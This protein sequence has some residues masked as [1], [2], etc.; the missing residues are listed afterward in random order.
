MNDKLIPRMMLIGVLALALPAA[1][2]AFFSVGISVGFAPPALPL[3]EQPPCPSSGYMWTPGYWAYSAE[4]ADY[5]WVPGTWV[6]APEPGLL[7]TP[8]YWA[9]EEGAYL[10]N[11]GYWAPHVGFYGGINYGYGYFGSGFE[12]GYW[13][14]HDFY[15]N[16]AVTNISNVSITNVYNRTVL[17]SNYYGNRPSFNGAAGVRASPTGSDLAAAHEPHRGI[18][19]P[20]RLQSTSAQSVRG[21]RASINHGN[22]PVAATAR[23]GA[24]QSR[25][26]EPAHYASL[27]SAGRYPQQLSAGARSVAPRTNEPIAR[28]RQEGATVTAW[29]SPAQ[30][31]SARQ[32]PLS[33]QAPA[34]SYQSAPAYPQVPRTAYSGSRYGD[35]YKPTARESFSQASQTRM[36]THYSPPVQAPAARQAP[37]ARQAPAASYRPIQTYAQAPRAAYSVNRNGG[38]YTP[39]AGQASTQAPRNN[40]A[41]ALARETPPPAVQERRR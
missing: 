18:T 12:G 40:R 31:S 2:F 35:D 3:Y 34:T 5:Y 1:S 28:T 36:A 7:W 30:A 22:P 20:Q 39:P 8:G 17:N 21:L 32:A 14:E 11:A 26:V 25:D 6:V 13:R 16:R 37:T 38:G 41:S 10:W 4:E 9:I 23:P 24:F 29:R 19:Q 27:A 33:R 15:Y